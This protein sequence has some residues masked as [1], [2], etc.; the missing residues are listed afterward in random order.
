MQV[1]YADDLVSLTKALE[2]GTV[3][4]GFTEGDLKA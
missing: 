2:T 3:I 1:V 4:T